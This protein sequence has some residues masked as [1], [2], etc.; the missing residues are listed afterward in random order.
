[1]DEL[2]VATDAPGTSDTNAP[3]VTITTT[4]PQNIAGD[5]LGVT[6]TASDD[7]WGTGSVCKWRLGSAP[8]ASNGTTISGLTYSGTV[9]WSFTAS[10]FSRGSNTLYVGCRDAVPNWG[11]KSMIVNYNLPAAVTNLKIVGGD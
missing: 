11:S 1:M 4:S 6:G 5:S 9:D 7:V 2:I 8:D 10:G 3:A